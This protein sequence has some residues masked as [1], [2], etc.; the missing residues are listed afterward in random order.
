[1]VKWIVAVPYMPDIGLY[2]NCVFESKEEA[3]KFASELRGAE[4][5]KIGDQILGKTKSKRKKKDRR[6]QEKAVANGTPNKKKI[7]KPNFNGKK[8]DPVTAC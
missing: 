6:L 8:G 3:E 2:S 7:K 1:M 4:I 5:I